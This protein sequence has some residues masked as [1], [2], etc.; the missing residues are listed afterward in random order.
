MP[1]PE[2]VEHRIA[3]GV[4]CL[5]FNDALRALAGERSTCCILMHESEAVRRS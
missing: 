3:A 2:I 4:G 5:C 1:F